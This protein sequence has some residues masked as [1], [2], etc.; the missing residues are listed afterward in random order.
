MKIQALAIPVLLALT[1]LPL[2]CKST[3]G[4]DRAETTADKVVAVG[5]AAGQT[6]IHLDKTLGALE[7]IEATREQ[8][9][10][11]SF[12]AFSKSLGSFGSS[13][14]EL[15]STRASLKSSA[16][17]WFTEFEKQ[18]AAIQDEDLRKTGEKRLSAFREQVGEVSK[19]VDKLIEA[20][21]SLE[22]RLKDLRA[23]LGNDLTADGIKSVSGRIGDDVK[24][25]RK[26]AARLGE[27]SQASNELAGKLRA[28]RK[29]AP[30]K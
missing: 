8:E 27:L 11:P 23:F 21:G 7:Q 25:G 17:T 1:A 30:A 2:A 29:P 18:N 9:P 14:A 13:F 22:L 26:L 24:E 19:Q 15:R 4:H 5:G 20:T 3:E 28:A 10:K 12:D 6:Q 16:E